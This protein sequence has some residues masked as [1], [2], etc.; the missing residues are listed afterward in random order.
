MWPVGRSFHSQARVILHGWMRPKYT[1]AWRT[2]SAACPSS[3]TPGSG[4]RRRSRCGRASWRRPLRAGW[5]SPSRSVADVFYTALL[6]HVGCSGT[7]HEAARGL[8]RRDGHVRRR[9]RDGR[10]RPRRADHAAAGVVARA[11]LGRAAP[12]PRLLDHAGVAIRSDVRRLRLRGRPVH[13][14]TPGPV[15]RCPARGPRRVRGLERQGRLPGPQGRGGPSPVSCHPAGRHRRPV[16]RTSVGQDWRSRR[17]GSGPAA[18]STR[19][20]RRVRRPTRPA[21]LAESDVDDPHR[22]SSRPSPSPCVTASASR[23]TRHRRGIRRHRRPQVDVHA[24]ALERRRRTGPGSGDDARPRRDRRWPGST[25]AA[26]LHDLG[27]VGVSDEI[28]ERAGPLSA[29]QWEQVRLHA[30]HSERIL[31]RSSV[32]K[33]AAAIAGMHHERLDGSG[34][35]RG[36]A[37]RELSVSARILAVAD[38]FQ[39]MT[40]DRAHRPAMTAEDGRGPD[41]R[42]RRRRAA[43]RRRGGRR[44]RSRRSAPPSIDRRPAG[45]VERARGRGPPGGREGACRTA[46]S[47][48]RSRSRRGRPSTTSSTSTTRSAC[49]AARRPPSSRWSTG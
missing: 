13:G 35:H 26:L 23:L 3:R 12:D 5:A 44:R 8:W 28:W 36:S 46:R 11:A 7:A 22:R 17:S 32:L 39:A 16:L 37:A 38:A 10:H 48:R 2:S 40:Q 49:R 43:R 34:Y 20:W 15:G 27:R 45:G 33:P 30:Y 41:P 1:S 4:S 24:R 6:E 14:A 21:I 42:R 29:A 25:S 19:R 31:A 9:R 47:A 18:C